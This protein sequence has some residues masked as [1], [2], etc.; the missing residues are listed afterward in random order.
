MSVGKCNSRVLGL[1][2]EVLVQVHTYSE[3][4]TSR[5]LYRNDVVRTVRFLYTSLLC[6]IDEEVSVGYYH[7]FGPH[8][9]HLLE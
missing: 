4:P 9:Y 7:P 2:T 6:P 5:N 8:W 3:K 1:T